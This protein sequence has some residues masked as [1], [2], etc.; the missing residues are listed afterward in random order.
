MYRERAMVVVL[1]LLLIIF[2][3]LFGVVLIAW[4]SCFVVA[5]KYEARTRALLIAGLARNL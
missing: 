5:S 3:L 2:C 1:F 4:F